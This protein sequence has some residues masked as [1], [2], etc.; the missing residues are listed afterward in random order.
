MYR[1]CPGQSTA[2]LAVA[3][4]SNVA[5][6]GRVF[7]IL[8]CNSYHHIED[9]VAYFDFLPAQSFVMFRP[10]I[11]PVARRQTRGAGRLVTPRVDS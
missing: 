8:F 10:Q 3:S 6:T 7:H 4:R 2:I 5:R 9:Q 11:R 1:E